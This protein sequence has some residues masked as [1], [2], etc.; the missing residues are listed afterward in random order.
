MSASL[1]LI[2]ARPGPWQYTF[3]IKLLALAALVA[4]ADRLFYMADALGA[5]L[6]VFTLAL[7]LSLVALRPDL[8][9]SRPALVAAGRGRMVRLL[10]GRRSGP[11]GLALAWIALTMAV[12]LPRAA[13][14]GSGLRWA[15]RLVLHGLATPVRPLK[16]L[17]RLSR[18][19]HRSRGGINF[20][21]VVIALV[22]P[23]AGT[24]VFLSCS[25]RPI[26]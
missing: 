1:A 2:A 3:L 20:L 17:S 16:D 21:G 18:A 5:T 19:R 22:L 11:L 12:L 26:R 10:A 6:G 15:L 4:L 9:R 25:R 8:R 24:A 7:L 23:I 13:R 14:F